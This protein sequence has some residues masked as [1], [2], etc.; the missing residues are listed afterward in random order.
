MNYRQRIASSTVALILALGIPT[1]A[2]A[3]TLRIDGSSGVRPLAAAL[4]ER[5]AEQ[6]AD[7]SVEIGEGMGTSRRLEALAGGEI[8]IAT[9]SHGVDEADLKERGMALHPIARIAVV[10]G[11]HADAQVAQL[12]SEE[13][14]SIYAGEV[15]NWSELGGADLGIEPMTRPDSEVDAEVMRE[16]VSCL[17]DLTFA[18]DVVTQESSGQMARALAETPGAIGMTTSTRVEGSDGQIV[19]ITLD[20]VAPTVAAVQDGSYEFVRTAYLVTAEAP[21]K[22]E[23]E[24][25]LAFIK[26]AAGGEVIEA[27]GA[28]PIM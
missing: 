2:Q 28:I 17:A 12:S 15:T 25:F 19:P 3:E 14:C 10:F 24:D 18:D 27:N 21:E 11:A 8:D 20:G 6:K 26:S 16:G 22:A 13:V 1:A 7:L 23:V 9:A 4:A 5:F